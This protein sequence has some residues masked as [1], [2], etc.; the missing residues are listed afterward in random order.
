MSKIKL[1]DNVIADINFREIDFSLRTGCCFI[2]CTGVDCDD[3]VLTKRNL[4]GLS[5]PLE[6]LEDV[7]IDE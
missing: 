2:D 5:V 3:C 7:I 6:K 1:T 4:E